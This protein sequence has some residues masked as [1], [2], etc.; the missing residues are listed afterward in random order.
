MGQTIAKQSQIVTNVAPACTT[1]SSPLSPMVTLGAGCFWGTEKFVKK[2]FQ[3][4]FPNSIK[5]TSVGFMSPSTSAMKNPSYRQVCSGSSGHVEVLEVE[6]NDPQ[7]HYEELIRFFFQFHDPTTKNRQGNDQG[8]QYGSAIFVYDKDQR[9]IAEKVK[10]E[11]N[12]LVAK[13]TITSYSNSEVTTE[14]ADATE[15]FPAEKEH[16]D[17][18]ANN[19]GGYCNHYFRFKEFPQ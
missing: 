10:K 17:Y 12:A 9:A 13:G 8:P 1:L 19:P 2:D 14:I 11:V 15:Y 3:K 16:Q 18:L 5:S 7:T 4:R 6:L